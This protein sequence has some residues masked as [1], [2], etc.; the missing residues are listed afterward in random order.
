[1]SIVCPYCKKEA[2]LVT[3]KDIY[4]Y[5]SQKLADKFFYLCKPCG[6]YVGCHPGTK[7]ALGSL[8]NHELRQYR[9]EAHKAFDY[10]WKYGGKLNRS[11]AY[12]WLARA[13]GKN[14]NEAHIGMFNKDECEKLCKMIVKFKM[15]RAQRECFEKL[16][17]L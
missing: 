9:S 12:S 8:A 2:R 14:K 17:S 11:E 6:A 5:P 7:K 3:G 10:I 1:M 15:I 13:M 4:T 16:R